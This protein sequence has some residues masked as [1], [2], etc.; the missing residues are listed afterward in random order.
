[1]RPLNLEFHTKL[2]KRLLA[3]E[4]ALRHLTGQGLTI[5]TIEDIG[6]GLS[7]PYHGKKT[8][9]EHA[10]ALVYP[11]RGL[12]GSFYN[13]YGYYNI[14]GITRNPQGDVDWMSGDTRSYY[15]SPVLGRKSVFVCQSPRDLWPHWQAINRSVHA[16]Y[17]VL[18]AST[19]DSALPTEWEAPSFWEGWE[20][21]YC[22]QP[23]DDAGE[24]AAVR[25]GTSIGR[26]ARR[27]APPR[28]CGRTWGDFWRNGGDM[29]EFAT[30][31][32]VAPVVSIAV[33]STPGQ[34]DDMGRFPYEPI[35]IN[36]AFHGGHLYYTARVLRRE[37][38]DGT[39]E[40]GP[41]AR[42][43]ERL[44]TVV[45]R[46]D[47]TVHTAMSPSA[48]KGTKVK[49]RVLRLTDGT[50]LDRI[51]QSS[52]HTTWQWAS[53]GKYL[54]G[55]S[56]ARPLGHILKDVTEC[57]KAEVHLT[58]GEDFAIL[59]LIVPVTYAQAIFRS[60]PHIILSGPAG[61][62]VRRAGHLL[63]CACADALVSG[64]SSLTSIM[65]SVGDA[66]G[67][68]VLSDL[69]RGDSKENRYAE[70]AE[71][72]KL[73]S[74]RLTAT[75]VW[76]AAETTRARRLNLYGVKVV[77]SRDA[78]AGETVG[79]G[80]LRIRTRKP[81]PRPKEGIEALASGV[82][83]RLADLRDELHTWTFSNVDLIAQ[84][85]ER[86]YP[87]GQTC[88]DDLIAPLKVMATLSRDDGL[89]AQ[90]KTALARR[91]NTVINIDDP[92]EAIGQALNSL[93][94]QGYTAVSTT[95]LS[96]ELR[97]MLTRQYG[98]PVSDRPPPWFKPG[99]LGRLLQELEITSGGETRA[100]LWGTNLRFHTLRPSY[101]EKVRGGAGGT[102]G[103]TVARPTDFCR[104]C[105]D[106][107]YKELS[108][109]IMARRQAAHSTPYK[110]PRPGKE[111][112]V[113][114]RLDVRSE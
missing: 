8:G 37:A 19:H 5:E 42:Y 67:L 46:S 14:P 35:N 61:S 111:N 90:M 70:L 108:C 10:D 97:S 32:R 50:L 22:G 28:W 62:G 74:H 105:D 85:Y 107:R 110:L 34:A 11:L 92:A 55:E 4:K 24:Q 93:I 77:L 39:G 1:M 94:L 98:R 60:V 101:V 87:A 23:N 44:E 88:E 68:I 29:K 12:D 20:V 51:P 78:R 45:I 109:E 73:S 49:D 80:A 104:E 71:L 21:V 82:E 83:I 102:G 96:L 41:P 31:L 18:I 16:D 40:S 99:R 84:E 7:M 38:D 89:A 53:I 56:R 75:R 114:S 54:R 66:C 47:R 6:L 57:L 64:Q 81:S 9:C 76:A 95:H 65:R 72:L 26:D 33:R 25:L 15:S 13:K 17:M 69:S 2:K 27:V 58:S 100:R 36:G 43:A 63:A 112:V 52:R 79:S 106:C 3:N 48:P 103:A 91:S 113:G 86:H 30:L 59:A